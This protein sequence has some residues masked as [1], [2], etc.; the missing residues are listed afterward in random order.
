[1]IFFYISFLSPID[2]GT[3][4]VHGSLELE[5]FIISSNVLIRFATTPKQMPID[6]FA[7]YSFPVTYKTTFIFTKHI[8]FG[9]FAL[10]FPSALDC[11]PAAALYTLQHG[12][13]DRPLSTYPCARANFILALS[14]LRTENDLSILDV[15]GLAM[16]IPLR[17]RWLQALAGD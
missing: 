15:V 10:T 8:L 17:R 1:M 6:I 3:K 7:D 5:N 13:A 12:F 14:T 9:H 4:H 11:A 16:I 2:T